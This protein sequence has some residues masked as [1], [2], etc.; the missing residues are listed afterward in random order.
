MYDFL[1]DIMTAIL[2]TLKQFYGYD[3]FRPGQEQIIHAILNG[4]DVLG[5]MPTG[6]GK[7]LCYQIPAIS[8][9]GVTIVISPLISLMKDQVD[10]LQAMGVRA[11]YINSQLSFNEQED[12]LYSAIQGGLDL[13]YVSPERLQ[14]E[15]FISYVQQ[16]NVNLVAVD[17]AHC[18]SQWGHDFR[19][20]Y[21]NIPQLMD[22]LANRPP[23]AAFTATATKI[24]RE[25][26]INQLNLSAPFEYIASFDRPNL[27]FSV[28]KPK[29][30]ANE[31][32]HI[33]DDKESSIIYCNTR[34]NVE[35]VY[36]ILEKKGYPATM[37]HAG[38]SP[39]ER[40]QNQEDFLYD[41]KPI[42]VATNAFGMGIDKSNVRRV[43][44]YNM[45]LD[46]ESYYQ[47]AGRAGRD[48]APAEAILFY[49]GQDIITNTFL[50]EQ[51]N[52]PHAKANL[53]TM[54]TYCK[55]GSCLRKTILNYFD[56]IPEWTECEH[57]S[58]CNGEMVKTDVTVECQKILSCIY[59]MNQS[60][61]TGLVTD[62]L[63]GKSTSRIKQMNFDTLSTHGIMKEY[64][65]GD[66]KDII[67]IMI[68]EQYL[69]LGGEQYPILQFTAKTND[70]LQAKVS[71]SITKSLKE[72][73][74]PKKK[75]VENIEQYDTDLFEQLRE[76]RRGIAQ[77]MGKPPFIVFSDRS[78]IDMAAKFPQNEREF[79][80]I[81]G[82]G[83][84]K[85]EEYGEQ[86]LSVIK[87]FSENRSLDV[88]QLRKENV[89][90][91]EVEAPKEMRT[92]STFEETLLY[93]NEG[94]NIEEIAVLRGYSQ[95]TI[96]N[97]LC[98]L[99]R[100]GD[101]ADTAKLVHS[102]AEAEIRSAVQEV[103]KETL[104][105]IKEAVSESISY[106]E[107]KIVL[108]KIDADQSA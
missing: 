40:T 74:A 51:G 72:E 32:V 64:T 57:C 68:S 44:H 47:E 83:E 60:Y 24:V 35:K 19:P 9:E 42:M 33:L 45:P 31:L 107:I 5:V 6:G 59:R 97:H 53:N 49:S 108:A 36:Q 13:M 27:Y 30:K 85:L 15:N 94:K 86:F 88:D 4:E 48:G 67:S 99:I 39:F 18:V 14:N 76:L 3:S 25:D 79:L 56:E 55:T 87:E 90:E 81:N 34:K 100:E 20:S 101:L 84:A 104:K 22:V 1:E 61:G 50:I 54:I 28:V 21:H 91:K 29:K 95:T 37:Y 41:R 8:M 80:E 96:I 11:A 43:I 38:I 106:E 16:M 82:V 77:E 66:I 52:N 93:F 62:V 102:E 12:I 17:E 23:F 65:D 63:R 71:L 2:D 92:G 7:S 78:L 26:M 89:S 103:G 69:Q 105:P 70:L 58:N 73:S 10:S 98:K 75:A 46:M